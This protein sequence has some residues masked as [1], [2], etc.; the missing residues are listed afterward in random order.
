MNRREALAGAI[1]AMELR[2]LL[3]EHLAIEYHR[4]GEALLPERTAARQAA[5]RDDELTATL[6]VLKA[7]RDKEW[8]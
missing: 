5:R 4:H 7:E 8:S 6:E 3:L 2:R 1:E